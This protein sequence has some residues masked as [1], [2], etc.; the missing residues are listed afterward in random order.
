MSLQPHGAAG[1]GGND[2]AGPCP[3]PSI[4]PHLPREQDRAASLLYLGSGKEED[5]SWVELGLGSVRSSA[6]LSW[7]E[8]MLQSGGWDWALA[9]VSG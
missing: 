7:H 2:S 6:G 8:A 3:R 5:S 9:L 4:L 1:W